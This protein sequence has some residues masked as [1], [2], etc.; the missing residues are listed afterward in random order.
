MNKYEAIIKASNEIFNR[1]RGIKVNA[2]MGMFDV[3]NDFSMD[4]P[5]CGNH[6]TDFQTKDNEPLMN[7]VDKDSVNEFYT[8]CDDC[9]V[10]VQFERG[11]NKHHMVKPDMS[12]YENLKTTKDLINNISSSNRDIRDY[13]TWKLL[14]IKRSTNVRQIKI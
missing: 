10:W 5:I 11:Y 4:C 14:P 1:T 12:I 2:I 6:L 3:I 7:R 9:S 13:C 8:M